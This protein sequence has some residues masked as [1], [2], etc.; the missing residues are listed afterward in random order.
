MYFYVG[1]QSTFAALKFIGDTKW[2][3]LITKTYLEGL[4]AHTPPLPQ[5]PLRTVPC[6]SARAPLE[7]YLTHSVLH[8][9]S[10]PVRRPVRR[11]RQPVGEGSRCGT[12]GAHGGRRLGFRLRLAPKLERS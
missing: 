1:Y 3:S 6:V 11:L 2:L 8:V 5:A 12:G 7:H 4:D 9:V 10:R